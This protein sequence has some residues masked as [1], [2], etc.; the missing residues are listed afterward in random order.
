MKGRP[1]KEGWQL[2]LR[3]GKQSYIYAQS[4]L[5][6]RIDIE[7]DYGF[8]GLYTDSTTLFRER[9][10]LPQAAHRQR[11]RRAKDVAFAMA[12]PHLPILERLAKIDS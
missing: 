12:E 10:P 1:T 5:H 9:I 11:L 2:R 6:L 3:K 4:G 8:V 7:Q